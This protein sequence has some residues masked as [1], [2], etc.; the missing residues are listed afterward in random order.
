MSNKNIDTLHQALRDIGAVHNH[1]SKNKK[2]DRQQ[3]KRMRRSNQPLDEKL[4]RERA[5]QKKRT[6][7]RQQKLQPRQSCLSAKG[8]AS[9]LEESKSFL[10]LIVD[11]LNRNYLQKGLKRHG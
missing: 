4:T 8:Q 2:R 11:L 6:P 7:M 9:Q 10:S 3:R 5:L 1:T